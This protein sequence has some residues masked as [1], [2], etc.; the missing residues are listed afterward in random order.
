[1]AAFAENR[2]VVYD[3]RIMSNLGTTSG[4]L[5]EGWLGAFLGLTVLAIGG[6]GSGGD[7]TVACRTKAPTHTEGV[8]GCV[9]QSNDVGNPPPPTS[10]LPEFSVEIFP[11]EPPPTPGDGLVPWAQTSSDSQG[12]YEIGLSPGDY[13]I[14]TAFRRC[15]ELAV[16]A[17]RCLAVD[18]DFG[19]GPGWSPR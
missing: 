10:A 4:S 13:W 5:P 2:Q 11:S 3:F 15:L 9:T 1:M 17:G 12:Y 18:Y 16:P 8:Y 6:C 19:V 7:E 14:C